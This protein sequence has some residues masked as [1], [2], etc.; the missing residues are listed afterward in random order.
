MNTF[1]WPASKLNTRDSY[2]FSSVGS[3]EEGSEKGEV[4]GVVSSHPEASPELILS[5][6]MCNECEFS[7]L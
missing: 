7:D 2:Q 6:P 3:E 1:C 4:L 5:S